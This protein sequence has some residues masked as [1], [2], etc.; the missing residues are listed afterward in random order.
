[1]KKHFEQEIENL[2]KLITVQATAV[3]RAVRNSLL[4]ISNNDADL[5]YFVI[6]GDDT[7]DTNEVRIEEE[8][9]KILALYQPVAGDLRYIVTL[10][11]VN[12]ELERIGDLAV[13]IA[14]RA[15]HLHSMEQDTPVM[16]FTT[17][18]QAVSVALKKSLDSFLTHNSALAEEVIES[19][20]TIDELHRGNI[21]L[22]KRLLKEN[23]EQTESI[24]DFMTIS[25][26]L[27]RIADS[28]TNIGED[29]IYLELGKIVRHSWSV[30]KMGS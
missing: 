27:E 26:N 24:L 20:N 6:I 17:M 8:C 22:V 30:A 14:E 7:L 29:V 1:M 28:C 23:S 15:M 18:F 3:E 10:L 19:D 9:L 13:N 4:S 21:E 25:R 12:T 2:N 11:K 5:A 16:D